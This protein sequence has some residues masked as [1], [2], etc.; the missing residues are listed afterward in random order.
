[1]IHT[2]NSDML[3]RVGKD[4]TS[5][6]NMPLNKALLMMRVVWL[7]MML[8]PIMFMGVIVLKVLPNV[9][10]PVEPQSIMNP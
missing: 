4:Q 1:M 10:Q 9:Q 3:D 2:G 8:A 5:L 7:G 6:N